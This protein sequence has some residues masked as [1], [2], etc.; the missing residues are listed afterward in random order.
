MNIWKSNIFINVTTK[1]QKV[2]ETL[3]H[4]SKN[5]EFDRIKIQNSIVD[6]MRILILQKYRKGTIQ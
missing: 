1:K 4:D 3:F 6:Y 2:D 5:G